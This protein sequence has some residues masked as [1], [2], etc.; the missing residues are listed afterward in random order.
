[1]NNEKLK[2]GLTLTHAISI[3]IGSIIGTGVF[4]KTATMTQFLG[5]PYLVLLAW[6]IGGLLSL[7][8]ALTYAELG[9]LVNKSGGEFEYLKQSF[10]NFVAFLFGWMRFWIGSPG[11]IAAYAVGAMT[12][13][14]SFYSLEK[15][16]G[17]K[18]CAIF[19]IILFSL[20]NCLKVSMAGKIQSFLTFLKIFIILLLGL[21]IFFYTPN[22]NIF[23]TNIYLPL[24]SNPFTISAFASALLASL[25]AYDGWNNLSMV[26]GEIIDPAKNIPKALSFGVFGVFLIYGFINLSYFY[27]LPISEIVNSNSKLYPDSLPVATKAGLSFLGNGGLK[28]ISIAFILSALG[29]MNG[30]ILTGSRVPYA[31]ANEGL[32]F[33]S[34]KKISHKNSVP[35]MSIFV[36]GVI[37]SLLSISGTFDQLT[38]YVVFAAWIFYALVT[39][40]IFKYRKLSPI[41]MRSKNHYR[42]YGYPFIPILFIFVAFGLLVNT[43]YTSPME[44]GIGLLFILS[45][46]PFYFYF[47]NSL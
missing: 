40:S 23:L 27:A 13:L 14:N 10:G 5:H 30:S 11:A 16:G 43:I 33:M 29:A 37:A 4:L 20:I 25:W 32:F 6:F 41:E 15:F 19:V 17:K 31:M 24:K 7:A 8:G 45:G 28:F 2:R 22:S 1:M 42:I 18:I 21:G 9:T 26:S 35:V 39:A 12:F 46:V 3:V 36:Q 38:D 44:S 47:K 34:I